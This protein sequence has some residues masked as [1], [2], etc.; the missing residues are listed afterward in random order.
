MSSGVTGD[1]GVSV[2]VAGAVSIPTLS[3]ASG[4]STNYGKNA[5][6]VAFLDGYVAKDDK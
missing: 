2:A 1:K 4:S 6:A 5:T 3:V